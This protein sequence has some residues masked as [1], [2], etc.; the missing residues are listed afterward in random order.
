MNTRDSYKF[1]PVPQP[2][3]AAAVAVQRG[4]RPRRIIITFTDPFD[5]TMLSQSN[6]VYEPRRAAKGFYTRYIS[7]CKQMLKQIQ[8]HILEDREPKVTIEQVA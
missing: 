5:D 3:R 2:P 7:K 8:S 4:V 6:L 1:P